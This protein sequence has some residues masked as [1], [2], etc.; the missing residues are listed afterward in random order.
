MA[1]EPEE[2]EE[3][4]RV[5]ELISSLEDIEDPAERFTRAGQLL[6][7]WNDEQARIMAIRQ[8]VVVALRAEKVSYRKIAQMLGVSLVRVQQIEKGKSV[9]A[10]R[11]KKPK[12]ADETTP[13]TE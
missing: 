1:N 2:T 8:A 9:S 11:E 3:V 6:A 13:K 12:P 10:N 4:R 7:T 5:K